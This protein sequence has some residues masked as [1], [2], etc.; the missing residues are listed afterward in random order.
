MNTNC[1]KCNKEMEMHVSVRLRLPGRY[2]L[3]I[4]KGV[5]KKK[6][7]RITAAFWEEGTLTCYDCGYR[8]KGI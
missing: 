7:C 1:P 2:L 6:E 8:Q 5:L 3:R 4:T